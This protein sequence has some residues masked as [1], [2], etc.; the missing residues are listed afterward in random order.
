[1]GY[2]LGLAASVLYLGA[3]GDRYG[4]KMM[5]IVGTALAIPF[6]LLAAWAPNEAVLFV[7]RVGGGL[8]AV[9]SPR[10]KRLSTTS[11]ASERKMP[12]IQVAPAATRKIALDARRGYRLRHPSR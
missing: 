8:A 3:L 6:S 9:A 1:M 10:L 7:A 5:L 2:S 12:A 11:V 4:R